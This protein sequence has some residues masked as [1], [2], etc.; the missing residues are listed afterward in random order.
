VVGV[1]LGRFPGQMSWN[2]LWEWIS[3]IMRDPSSHTMSAL[4]GDKYVPHPSERAQWAVFEAWLNTQTPKGSGY[5]R[6]TR[7]WSGKRP[8]YTPAEAPMSAQ[9]EARRAKLAALF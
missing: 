7:P 8:S 4:A 3:E 9:R 2:L 1:D 5:K 6:V